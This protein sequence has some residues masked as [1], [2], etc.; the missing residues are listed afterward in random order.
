[1]PIPDR[2]RPWIASVTCYLGLREIKVGETD[3]RKGRE[4]DGTPCGNRVIVEG[5]T[6]P[7]LVA[8]RVVQEGVRPL[9]LG[10]FG[11]RRAEA[12]VLNDPLGDRP[13]V[14]IFTVVLVIVFVQA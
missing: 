10:R 4:C 7:G 1:M 6:W 9:I 5:Q 12:H 2:Y 3:P 14:G 13:R 8:T 11:S